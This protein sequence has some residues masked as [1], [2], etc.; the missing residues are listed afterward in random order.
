MS[1]TRTRTRSNTI[2]PLTGQV[3][4]VGGTGTCNNPDPQTNWLTTTSVG[5]S[6]GSSEV[7]IDVSTP[8]FYKLSR[9]GAVINNPMIWTKTFTQDGLTSYQKVHVHV[10]NDMCTPTKPVYW[11][12]N[13][14][15]AVSILSLM[16]SDGVDF[17]V[18]PASPFNLVAQ[19]TTSA[20]ANIGKADVLTY[21]VMFEAKKTLET[22][23]NVFRGL[24]SLNKAAKALQT[25]EKE[26]AFR[27]LTD[28]EN[29]KLLRQLR[30]K[31][32]EIRYGL[33][34]LLYDLRGA[35]KF[36]D[37][38]QSDNGAT[39]RKTV[40]GEACSDT[41]D[42]N[43]ESVVQ[44]SNTNHAMDRVYMFASTRLT[45]AQAGVLTTS[46]AMGRFI[47]SLGLDQFIESGWEI[48]PWSFVIDWFINV[49][50]TMASWTP[51]TGFEAL[52]SWCRVV[53]ICTQKVSVEVRNLSC[54][55]VWGSCASNTMTL[56][57]G[58]ATKI[59]TSISRTPDV[60][61]DVIPSIKFKWNPLTFLDALALL[62]RNR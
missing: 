3:N 38:S 28:A 49:G 33:R 35:F 51:N 22:L 43:S 17:P 48:F 40:R 24:Y 15:G 58:V 29:A 59:V 42:A 32:L 16:A 30:D 61:R 62:T 23:T 57:G 10:R 7:M 47:A 50:E 11:R 14:A 60:R 9:S 4:W 46:T 27:G 1:V 8:E 55:K 41:V 19:A 6:T 12:D 52:A 13:G 44:A 31:W 36:W 54:R 26:G 53:D 25:A 18:V 56:S 5:P 20:W 37:K 45:T 39:I 2:N 21:T 34:P